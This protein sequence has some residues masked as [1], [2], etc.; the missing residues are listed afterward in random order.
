MQDHV[1]SSASDASPVENRHR[2]DAVMTDAQLFMPALTD[3]LYQVLA[4]M[5][6]LLDRLLRIHIPDLDSGKCVACGR[7]GYGTPFVTWPC[8]PAAAAHRAVLIAVERDAAGR[9]E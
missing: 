7:P 3:A 6:D 1:S 2:N 8:G 5:P 4:D 9:E